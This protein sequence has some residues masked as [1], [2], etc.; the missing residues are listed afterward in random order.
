MFL[1]THTTKHDGPASGPIRLA[2][3]TDVCGSYSPLAGADPG[4]A[5]I[6]LS[7]FDQ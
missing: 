7:W 1:M 2:V 4:H 5:T 3:D 6:H